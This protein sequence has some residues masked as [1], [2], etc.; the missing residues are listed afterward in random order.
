MT[1]LRLVG[2][3]VPGLLWHPSRSAGPRP[4]VLIG[5]GGGLHKRCPYVF[6]LARRFA[7]R[8]W[9]AV[10]LDAPDMESAA[11]SKTTPS[12]VGHDPIRIRSSASGVPA[13]T[14]CATY[15]RATP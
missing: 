8:G 2:E 3:A 15:Q 9:T 11:H 1:A 13:S 10:A 14:S 4:T 7:G 5:H 12:R 6:R